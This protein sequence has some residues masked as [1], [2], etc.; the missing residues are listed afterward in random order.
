MG[1]AFAGTSNATLSGLVW[2][3]APEFWLP[4]L[5]VL[6]AEEPLHAIIR[7][8]RVPIGEASMADIVSPRIWTA[9]TAEEKED[10]CLAFWQG[11][12]ALSR[13]AQPRVLLDLAGALRFREIFLKRMTAADKARH[14]RRLI[15]GPALRQY[16]DDVLRSWL[17]VR[18]SAML[19][20]F[21][22][23]QGMKH[24]DGI[25]QDESA[26]PTAKSLREGIQAIKAQF[27]ARDVALYMAV[28]STAGGDFWVGLAD[29]VAAEIPDLKAMLFTEKR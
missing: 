1:H 29:A 20:C 25:I 7:P 26:P 10:A 16:E 24:V 19:V 22:E 3:L 18:K 2:I 17:V 13:E 21:V 5:E 9:L 15:D 4:G 14:L 12:D 23:T 28:M 6:L 8:F 27:P 11:T